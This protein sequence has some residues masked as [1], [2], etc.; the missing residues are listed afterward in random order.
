MSNGIYTLSHYCNMY[1][2]GW[3]HLL[4]LRM[5]MVTQVEIGAMPRRPM[6]IS[7]VHSPEVLFS[8]WMCFLQLAKGCVG[9][10]G[11]CGTG[12]SFRRSAFDLPFS[13]HV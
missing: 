8:I 5:Y 11:T 6:L 10:R 3:H 12:F 4:G 2:S 13:A 1:L 9:T 7:G